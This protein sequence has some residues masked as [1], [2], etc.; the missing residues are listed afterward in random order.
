MSR[1]AG[2]LEQYHI[3]DL[4]VGRSIGL[5]NRRLC[6]HATSST[7]AIDRGRLNFGIDSEG[8]HQ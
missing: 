5:G 8:V 7:R 3:L 2:K 4:V 1:P 6:P